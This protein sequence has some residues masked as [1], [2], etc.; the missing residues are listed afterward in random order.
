MSKKYIKVTYDN[1]EEYYKKKSDIAK[2]F[3]SSSQHIC[4]VLNGVSKYNFIIF[5]ETIVKLEYVDYND[6][7]NILLKRQ[8]LLDKKIIRD[9]RREHNKKEYQKRKMLSQ[10][11]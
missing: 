5:N 3:N 7:S 4:N 8:K 9:K 11:I 10:E 2:K 6:N 1:N